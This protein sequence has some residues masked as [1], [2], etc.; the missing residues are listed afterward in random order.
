ML[1]S[2]VE[3]LYDLPYKYQHICLIYIG[4]T[5]TV[6][7]QKNLFIIKQIHTSFSMR[8]SLEQERMRV[9]ISNL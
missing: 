5:I 8:V 2:Y 9:I 6:Q 4:W 3:H 1:W 7:K